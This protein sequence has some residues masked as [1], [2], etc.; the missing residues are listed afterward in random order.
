[1]ESDMKKFIILIITLVFSTSN[2]MATLPLPL[3]EKDITGTPRNLGKCARK[4]KTAVVIAGAAFGA[5]ASH[6]VLKDSFDNPYVI[7]LG[8]IALTLVV[9]GQF[10]I[11]FDLCAECCC[12]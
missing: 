5:F 7:E 1:M 3:F 6:V 10:G 8:K 2:A 9:A 11:V 4:A 12:L